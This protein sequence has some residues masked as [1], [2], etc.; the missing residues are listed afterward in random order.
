MSTSF[1]QDVPTKS[2][3]PTVYKLL[4]RLLGFILLEIAFLALVLSCTRS[5]ILVKIP[6]SSAEVKGGFTVL[7]IVWH[8]VAI[9]LL[10]DATS[11]AFSSEWSRQYA[12]TGC[13]VPGITD[14]VSRL[15]SGND[16]KTRYFL[17]RH[18]SAT[19]RCA[20]ATFLISAAL[21]SF[22]PGSLSVSKVKVAVSMPMRVADLRLVTSSQS[23]DNDNNLNFLQD[24]ANTLVELEHHQDSL[25]KYDME[26]NWLMAW[27][28][29]TSID[30]SV[31]GNVEYP[32]DVIHFNYSC[33]WRVPEMDSDSDATTWNVDGHQWELWG[34]PVGAFPYVGGE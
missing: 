24:R 7:F 33:D 15:T 18:P 21:N 19:F 20:F 28:D 34:D 32:T 10:S 9:F 6:L 17:T 25:F 13:L 29:E 1:P 5:P 4:R 12:K 30:P 14:R 27:P 8:T 23:D 31:V 22:A 26:A 3:R 2:N 16:D 11:F